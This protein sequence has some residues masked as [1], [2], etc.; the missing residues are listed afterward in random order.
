MPCGSS[1][2]PLS[3]N[4]PLCQRARLRQAHGR[5]QPAVLPEMPERALSTRV[6][7]PFTGML[8]LALDRTAVSVFNI[9]RS[10]RGLAG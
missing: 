8:H 5:R 7:A 9:A 3:D 10:G 6:C 2:L 4:L 1:P